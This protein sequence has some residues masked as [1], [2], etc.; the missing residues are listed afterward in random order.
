MTIINKFIWKQLLSI[1]IILPV[2]KDL[3]LHINK[4][5]VFVCF[6][7]KNSILDE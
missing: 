4:I 3:K 5:D 6:Y 1:H 2:I 7:T